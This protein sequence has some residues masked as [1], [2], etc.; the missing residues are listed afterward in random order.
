MSRISKGLSG[1]VSRKYAN[2]PNFPGLLDGC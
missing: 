1:W 2:F